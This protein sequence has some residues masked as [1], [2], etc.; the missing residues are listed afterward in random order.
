MQPSWIVI[1]CLAGRGLVQRLGVGWGCPFFPFNAC[2]LGKYFLAPILH[3]Y[4]IQDGSL[5]LKCAL[6]CPKQAHIAALAM[7]HVNDL[8]PFER[9]TEQTTETMPP[10]PKAKRVAPFMTHRIIS[11]RELLHYCQ[12]K[13]ACTAGKSVDQ[14][15]MKC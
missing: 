6:K 4:Q 3:S 14:V 10:S 1:G 13:P 9:T 5:K 11:L 2:S 12:N 15:L 7:S 8:K